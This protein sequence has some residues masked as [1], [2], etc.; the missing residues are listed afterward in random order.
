MTP[1]RRREIIEALRRGAVPRAG[2][3]L[4]AV[5][6]DRFEEAVDESL[7][8]V[9]GG[10]GKFKAV[11]GEYGTGKTFFARWLQERARAE[12]FA[13][14]EVQIS[15][16]E[17]Y[18]HKMHTV[19]RAAMER[20]QTQ[21]TSPG[22]LT[23]ILEEWFFRLERDALDRGDVDETDDEAV[24]AAVTE[25]LEKRLANIT[26]VPPQFAASLRA[27]W[28]AT[29][30][31][32]RATAQA[33]VAWMAGKPHVGQDIKRE[34][35]LK[36]S[37]DHFGAINFL[38]GLLTLLKGAGYEGLVLVLDE[39]ETLQRVRSDVREK[40]LNALRQLIDYVDE[41][42][43]PGL[44]ILVTG[45]PAFFDGP[46]GVQRSEPLAQRLATDF[47]TAPEFDNPR[48]AQ[49]RLRGLTHDQLVEL[50]TKIRDLIAKESSHP[51]RIRTRAD[52]TYI[53]D[54]ADAVAGEFGDVRIAPRLFLKKLVADVL[55][56]IDVHES[57]DPRQNY[58]LT[59]TPQE[60]TEEEREAVGLDDVELELE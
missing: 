11:R 21:N 42:R 23:D 33:L 30:E 54:L 1:E 48:A 31:R 43:F 44:Y 37:L 9:A 16:S 59:F 20:I 28:A 49:I 50:G 29:R 12:G 47:E 51:E 14:S 60:M 58:D 22:D 34:A 35:D 39:A 4:L 41:G 55:D 24:E 46:Q 3:G 25:Q 7:D 8:Y 38:R 56:R 15:E 6:L 32:D 26:T 5:G 40:S 10:R 52:D 18:L 45:T 53:E 17:T 57:F 36:G 2:L 19:Y 27:Y 13:T